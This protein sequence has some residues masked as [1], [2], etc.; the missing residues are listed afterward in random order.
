MLEGSGF[1]LRLRALG[2]R[3]RVPFAAFRAALAALDGVSVR[4]VP[5]A[6]Q[7]EAEIRIASQRDE[8]LPEEQRT[9]RR[10]SFS[11]LRALIAAL[12]DEPPHL[13]LYGAFGYDLVRQIE[14]LREPEGQRRDLV[15]YLPDSVL[16]VDRQRGDAHRYDYDFAFAGERTA[17]IARTPAAAPFRPPAPDAAG[18]RDHEPGE[19][20]SWC[21]G[22]G[23]PSSAAS[24]SRRCPAR[25]SV[26]RCAPAPRPCSRTSSASTRPP[27]APS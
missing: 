18:W 11:V 17:G 1:G 22:P 24:C 23:A 27:T 5:G 8:P 6:P 19:T 21:A 7:P 3:G 20:P 9:R 25:P 13:G 26:G 16:A 15:V 14:A 4:D 10:L 2:E 12:P